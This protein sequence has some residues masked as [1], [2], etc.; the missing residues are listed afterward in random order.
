M[1]YPSIIPVAVLRPLHDVMVE[2]KPERKE[3][4][5]LDFVSAGKYIFNFVRY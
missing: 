2:T 1:W 3:D 5:K 4:L